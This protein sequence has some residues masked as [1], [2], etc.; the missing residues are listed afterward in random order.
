MQGSSVKQLIFIAG[1]LALTA[2]LYFAPRNS[3]KIPESNKIS[4]SK[5]D[6]D[7]D[8]LLSFQEKNLTP[9]E[10]QKA[11]NWKSELMQPASRVNLSFYDSLA[12][13]WDSKKMLALSA[14]YFELKAGKDNSEKSFL[15]AAY[16]FFDAYKNALDSMVKV[17][18]AEKSIKYYSEVLKLNPKNMDAK[19]DLGAL[20][21]EATSDPMKGI[22]MLREV[23][24]ENPNH[25]NAQLNLGFLSVKSKQY[26]KALE[27]FDNVLRINPENRQ[28]YL[29][30]AQVYEQMNNVGKAVENYQQFLKLSGNKE[31]NSQIEQRIRELKK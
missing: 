3:K 29:Y 23:V 2:V 14:H 24:A 13:L 26:E 27:R 1:T 7:F 17:S 5:K 22:L 31:V 30:K 12:G 15:N 6:F 11:E 21:A 16:R 8:E 28:V 20:Y 19:T 9:D 18:M 4:E 25:E 10:L